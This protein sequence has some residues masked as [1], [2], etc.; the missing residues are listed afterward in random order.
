MSSALVTARCAYGSVY[1]RFMMKISRVFPNF[2]MPLCQ[3]VENT[4]P[5]AVCMCVYMC[6]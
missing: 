5:V 3:N 6:V 4:F 2:A 1:F